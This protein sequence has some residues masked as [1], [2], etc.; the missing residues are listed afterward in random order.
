MR[1]QDFKVYP[2]PGRERVFVQMYP[3]E[4]Q[5]V[6]IQLVNALGRTVYQTTIEQAQRDP[7][8]LEAHGLQG[9]RL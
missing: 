4:G 8:V 9:W 7:F 1:Y 2:N 6:D 3:F 5:R